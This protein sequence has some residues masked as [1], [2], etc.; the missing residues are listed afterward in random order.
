[1][2]V[3]QAINKV[4][5]EGSDVF[6]TWLL[7]QVRVLSLLEKKARQKWGLQAEY[8]SYKARTPVL[9]PRIK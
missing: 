2:E 8:G 3:K 7:T 6:V 9:I 5:R 1:M 4:R